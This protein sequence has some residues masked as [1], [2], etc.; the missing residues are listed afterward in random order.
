MRCQYLHQDSFINIP[1]AW[2]MYEN[3]LQWNWPSNYKTTTLCCL[4]HWNYLQVCY[5]LPV[6]AK[7]LYHYTYLLAFNCS[8]EGACTWMILWISLLMNTYKHYA[9]HTYEEKVHIYIPFLC[10]WLYLCLPSTNSDLHVKPL[11]Q[12][13]EV[14]N[15]RM[16]KE[17]YPHVTM[18]QK[19]NVVLKANKRWNKTTIRQHLGYHR[20]EQIKY[21]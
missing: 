21:S 3:Q 6:K 19:N 1:I 13:W 7:D 20:D 12:T 5:P 2:T 16:V 17:I 9:F 11:A 14:L 18:H 10:C 15:Y 8:N 4:D